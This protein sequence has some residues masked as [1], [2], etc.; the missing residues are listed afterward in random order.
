MFRMLRNNPNVHRCSYFELGLPVL[1]RRHVQL[2]FVV[3]FEMASVVNFLQQ[4]SRVFLSK[5]RRVQLLSGRKVSTGRIHSDFQCRLAESTDFDAVVKLSEGLYNGYDF[6]PVVYHKWL[7]KENVAMMLLYAGKSLIGL[8]AGCIVDEG[9]TLVWRAA[10]VAHNLEGQG[11]QRKLAVKLGEHVQ[12]KFPE[13]SRIRTATHLEPQRKSRNSF[14]KIFE[15]DEL[16]FFVEEKSARK[17]DRLNFRTSLRTEDE[18]QVQSCTKEYFA[19]I[20]L[21]S[22]V[23]TELCPNNILVFDWCPYEPLRSNVDL[24]LKEDHNTHFFADEN[25]VE[26]CPKSFSY[27]VHAKTVE[28]VKWEASVYSHDPAIFQA[29]LLHQFK[30]ACE[31]IDSKFT[32]FSVQ[33]RAMT[34]YARK[35]L[36]EMLQLKEANLLKGTTMKVFERPF[37]R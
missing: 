1:P 15:R 29:H 16:S 10:R 36:G 12:A 3:F 32:F 27:G 5:C 22:S 23:I 4:R 9:K 14:E 17:F 13:V 33:D 26:S 34:G 28:T 35:I 31:I 21:S 18:F 11:L 24:I 25:S 20:M 8:Q 37:T 30:R 2:G 6:L 19:K 7:K